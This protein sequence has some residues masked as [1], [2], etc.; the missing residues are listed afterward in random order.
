VSHLRRCPAEF[1]PNVVSRRTH[2][3][4]PPSSF[5]SERQKRT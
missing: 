1:N 3:N 2:P 4:G 5:C